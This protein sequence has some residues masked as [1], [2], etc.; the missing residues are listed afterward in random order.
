[1]AV[2]HRSDMFRPSPSS[3]CLCSSC[4]RETP[5]GA[6]TRTQG[7][8]LQPGREEGSQTHVLVDLEDHRGGVEVHLVVIHQHREPP[9]LLGHG[10]GHLHGSSGCGTGQTW[11]QPGAEG[12]VP[13]AETAELG[14]SRSLEGGSLR[15]TRPA[16][17]LNQAR[18]T[19]WGR[20]APQ[21]RALFP[22]A[23]LVLRL[24]G[25]LLPLTSFLPLI[26]SV[27]TCLSTSSVS[28]LIRNL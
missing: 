9:D 19:C 5:T 15:G 18:T 10:C 25:Y 8:P 27:L 21:M 1:M 6:P 28:C 22:G 17:P 12:T 20:E 23:Q 11:G 7:G 2:E 13:S 26:Y 4:S 24:V 14:R 16:L 3:M